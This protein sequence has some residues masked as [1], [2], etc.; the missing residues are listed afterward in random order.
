[1]LHYY[2]TYQSLT[3]PELRGYFSWRTKL[4][5]GDVQK[6]LC[7]THFFTST[8]FSTKSASQILWTAT[9]N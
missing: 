9:R 3:D 1:M 5:R 4:R 6:R 8:S 7:P 2:P